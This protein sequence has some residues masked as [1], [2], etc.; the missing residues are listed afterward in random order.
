MQFLKLPCDNLEI[1]NLDDISADFDTIPSIVYN[2]NETNLKYKLKD[3]VCHQVIKLKSNCYNCIEEFEI[4][5]Y[6]FKPQVETRRDCSGGT[7]I[8]IVSL[9]GCTNLITKWRRDTSDVLLNNENTLIVDST[10]GPGT[11]KFEYYHPDNSTTLIHSI[12]INVP[13]IDSPML[14]LESSNTYYENH[15]CFFS[16]KINLAQGVTATDYKF[17][18]LYYTSSA[19][20]IPFEIQVSDTS[21]FI[22]IYQEVECGE[23]SYKISISLASDTNNTTIC[24]LIIPFNCN[25]E[26][27]ANVQTGKYKN[28][29]NASPPFSYVN[30][31]FGDKDE[32]G[33]AIRIN[34][35]IEEEVGL[36]KCKKSFRLPAGVEPSDIIINEVNSSA[37]DTTYYELRTVYDEDSNEVVELYVELNSPCGDNN[38][39]GFPGINSVTFSIK[40]AMPNGD[41]CEY[42]QVFQCGCNYP[43][44]PDSCKYIAI[45]HIMMRSAPYLFSYS[46]SSCVREPITF[47]L[48]NALGIRLTPVYDILPSSPAQGTFPVDMSGQVPGVYFIVAEN[49][50]NEIFGVLQFI[51]Q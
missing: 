6:N 10:L 33:N 20:G 40:V 11:Y 46:D 8:T 26:N 24:D 12:E 36:M 48:Y 22:D 44:N 3:N 35:Q 9:N 2:G 39:F 34:P 1:T 29:Y 38:S 4:N 27:C 47:W 37:P 43:P 7:R 42:L 17:F 50:V 15:K 49:P 32:N 30:T 51:K 13:T 45:H 25:C 28:I 21:T 5:V 14:T 16:A 23:G 41:T 18:G 19:W 31:Y